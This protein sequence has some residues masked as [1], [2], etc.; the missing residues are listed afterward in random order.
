MPNKAQRWTILLHLLDLG[1]LWLHRPAGAHVKQQSGSVLMCLRVQHQ[2]SWMNWPLPTRSTHAHVTDKI[3]IVPKQFGLFWNLYFF[4]ENMRLTKI[5]NQ[6]CQLHFDDTVLSLR[7]FHSLKIRLQMCKQ[8]FKTQFCL[9]IS[10]VTFKKKSTDVE[11][12]K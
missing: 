1:M 10:N 11:S 3:K 6:V 2:I 5:K 8:R 9:H 4:A 7:N 12:K